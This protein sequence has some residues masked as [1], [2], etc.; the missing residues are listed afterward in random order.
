ML[1]STDMYCSSTNETQYRSGYV[2]Y[3]LHFLRYIN[4][5]TLCIYIL[6]YK[7]TNS[8]LVLLVHILTGIEFERY[9]CCTYAV[10]IVLL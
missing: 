6:L 7:S 1:K 9:F 3:V 2:L 4:L 10:L 8:F 5:N